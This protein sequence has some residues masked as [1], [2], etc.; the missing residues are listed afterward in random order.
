MFGSSTAS[1]RV[2]EEEARRYFESGNCSLRNK[3][4]IYSSFNPTLLEPVTLRWRVHFASCPFDSYLSLLTEEIAEENQDSDQ[5]IRLCRKA[6]RN[7]VLAFYQRREAV[8]FTFHLGDPLHCAITENDFD[9]IDCG[10]LPDRVGLINV[11]AVFGAK[12][13]TE[14]ESILLT[15]VSTWIS[16]APSVRKFVEEDLL[17]GISS[18]LMPSLYGMRLVFEERAIRP[19]PLDYDQLIVPL[20]PLRMKKTLPFENVTLVSSPPMENYLERLRKACIVDCHRLETPFTFQYVLLG[21]SRRGADNGWIDKLWSEAVSTTVGSH[22]ACQTLNA[23]LERH[24]LRQL[25]FSVPFCSFRLAGR[26]NL[27]LVLQK[28]NSTKDE[29]LCIDN[30]QIDFNKNVDD[31][32]DSIQI[33]FLL[34]VNELLRMEQENYDAIL[35]DTCTGQPIFNFGLVQNMKQSDFIQLH[36][37]ANHPAAVSTYG[38]YCLEMDDCYVIQ[39]SMDEMLKGTTFSKNLF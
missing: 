29:L 1:K 34:P 22:L 19:T 10:D 15:D 33:S 37:L 17:L 30:L 12:L 20:L 21:L 36:P 38:I 14:T 4:E 28:P 16:T 13:S 25:S 2:I 26:A 23:W 27:R 18:S 7:L 32:V 35:T 24:P 8:E 11:L 9:V 5:I 6:L 31:A 3:E 39:I